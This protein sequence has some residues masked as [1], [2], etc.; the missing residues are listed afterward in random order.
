M[1]RI[2]AMI[3]I[4]TLVMA[5]GVSMPAFGAAPDILIDGQTLYFDVVP[6]IESG[7]VL[8]PLRGIFEALGAQVDYVQA[9][10]TVVARKGSTEIVL[11][12]G[13][14]VALIDG[15]RVALEVSARIVDSRTLVPLRFVSEALGAQVFWDAAKF[16]VQIVSSEA[17]PQ[18][19]PPEVPEEDGTNRV[20]RWTF[21]GQ[22]EVLSIAVNADRLRYY[23]RLRRVPSDDYSLYVTHPGDD[24][25]L[26]A[27]VD[28]FR[29][30]AAARGYS[31]RTLAEYVIAFVQAME[32]RTDLDAND[33]EEYPQYPL[34]TLA[35]KGGDCEDTTI[36][37]A[38]LMK[39]MG[40]DAIIVH[41][42]S[43]HTGV[44][45]WMTFEGPAL[46]Y[47]VNDRVYT[48]VETTL[49]YPIGRIPPEFQGLRAKFFTLV[50]KPA[51]RFR[52]E[53]VSTGVDVRV[54]NEGT[55]ATKAL[56]VR[57]AFEGRDGR[58]MNRVTSRQYVIEAGDNRVIHLAPEYPVGVDY[59][60]V[61]SIYE[62]GV[63]MAED[64]SS[65]I[66]GSPL[67]T[68]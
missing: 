30:I 11:T 39:T 12:I 13:N 7:R 68:Q 42:P 14:S 53:T 44:G 52:W 23:Q 5:F 29:T 6:Q 28:R 18:G 10:R 41:F 21:R 37:L 51:I 16:Q 1:K 46:Q 3:I 19:L 25:D 17:V 24:G 22:P 49:P 60:F 64:R 47:T 31:T 67:P 4:G 2:A 62:N 66:P 58:L 50:P 8:V 34:E 9:T 43:V 26:R 20:F 57:V 63:L 45:L 48:Y 15:S 65:W 35:A 61:V 33:L 32:Y 40:H 27:L 55:G 59:R 56:T 54:Y 36:L 38:A